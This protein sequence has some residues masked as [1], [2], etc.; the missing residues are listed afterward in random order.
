MKMLLVVVPILLF[1]CGCTVTQDRGVQAYNAC[2]LRH[3]NET[4]LCEAPRDAY[5]PDVPTV[6][7]RP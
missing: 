4:P 7:A 6:A 5:Q 1:F 2:L 3:P